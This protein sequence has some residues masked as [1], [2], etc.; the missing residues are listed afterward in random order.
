MKILYRIS[1]S[2]IVFYILTSNL[3]SQ[4]TRVLDLQ[5]CINLAKEQSLE[6]LMLQE[7]LK[8]AEYELKAATNKFKTMVNLNLRAPDY[9]ESIESWDTG[10]G[11]TYY[12]NRKLIYDG[13]LE[14]KQP[15][16]TDGEIF[17]RS[18]INNI[19]DYRQSTNTLK[20]N[21]RI[22][23]KQ[24]IDAFFAYN[25]IQAEFKRANLN[26]ERWQKRFTRTELD[27]VYDVSKA[28]YDMLSA[29]ERKKIAM[30]D[31]ERQKD[32]HEVASNKFKAGLIRESEALQME[33][34]LGAAQNSY[35]IAE[36]NN[37][38]RANDLKEK[39]G[40]D[41]SDSIDVVGDFE[42]QE[43]LV[44]VEKAV[45]LGLEN[46]L[47]IREQEIAIELSEL[48]IKRKKSARFIK[49]DISAY[50]DFT[51]IGYEELG[52]PAFSGA[53][54]NIQERPGNRGV[55]LNVRI[56]LID[57]GVNKSLQ[58][59]AE[60]EKQLKIYGLEQQ[61]I[62]IE[63][64]IRNTVNNLHSSLSRL[65]L[66][67]KNVDLAEKNFEISRARFTNGDIDA[68]TVALDRSRLN[69]AYN[70]RLQAYIQYKLQIA[71]L[72]RKTFFDFEKGKVLAD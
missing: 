48:E 2:I 58:R 23:L 72:T 22:G 59:A 45:N 11:L 55:A 64:D 34:D 10:G 36:V 29:K 17:I 20:L 44:D 39:L 30:L 50:Y 56:P 27:L 62:K 3:H 32:A 46:R 49:G 13:N 21:T 7:N 67:N 25:H 57:W 69:N 5:A 54:S 71:D 53:F 65:Q 26:H 19:D 4:T 40:L 33:I 43:I 35:D 37:L 31:L 70:S 14:I 68:Q 66:L 15:L 63:K 16:P 1:T 60:S 51:G 9:R 42:Y 38:S 52:N 41:I 24:P 61:K 18:G 8:I 47:E 12:P 28:F 6:M